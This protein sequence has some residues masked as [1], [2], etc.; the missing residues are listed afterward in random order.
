MSEKKDD[1]LGDTD[2]LTETRKLNNEINA[3]IMEVYEKISKIQKNNNT[4]I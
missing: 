1:K 4:R 2:I 3:W